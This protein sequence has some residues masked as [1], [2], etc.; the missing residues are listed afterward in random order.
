MP[1]S[2]EAQ[3]RILSSHLGIG[4]EASNSSRKLHAFHKPDRGIAGGLHRALDR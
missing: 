4:A 2:V 3:A 1:S